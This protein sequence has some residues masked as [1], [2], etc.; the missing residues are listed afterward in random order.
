MSRRHRLH[1]QLAPLAPPRAHPPRP[2]PAPTTNAAPHAPRATTLRDPLGDAPR[3]PQAPIAHTFVVDDNGDTVNAGGA[4]VC[5]D[6]GGKCTLRAAIGA[7]NADGSN[8]DAIVVPAMTI[9]LGDSQLD[10]SNNMFINGAGPA[11]TIV[12]VG[13][14][15]PSSSHRVVGVN[16]TTNNIAAEI[17]GMTLT[18]GRGNGNGGGIDVEEGALT[19]GN[20]I[21][22]NNDTDGAPGGGIYVSSNGSL[23][24]DGSTI[25]G[26]FTTGTNANSAN[27]GGIYNNG[28]VNIKNTT[29]G[30]DTG[31]AK[32]TIINA[33]GG[34]LYNANVASLDNVAVKNNTIN[35]IGQT[36]GNGAGVYN[37]GSLQLNGGTIAPTRLRRL[38]LEIAE[39]TS[40]VA[41]GF[42]TT[43]RCPQ[44]VRRS[45]ETRSTRRSPEGWAFITTTRSP[46]AKS[47]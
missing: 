28:A 14:G 17:T 43:T 32:N 25:T 3:L 19:L 29:I 37:N 24:V 40:D 1:R 33:S 11:G 4:G 16:S 10:I 39:V 9:L 5:A 42:T 44:S 31:A 46:S 18:G 45:T 15:T 21:V 36:N 27:G 2:A 8:V 30:G 38:T 20:D 23:W 26:N 34:G 47:R 35:V 13:G 22:S 12:T 6:S 41:L 7:A